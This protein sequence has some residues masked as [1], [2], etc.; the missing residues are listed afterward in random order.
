MS[1][2]TKSENKVRRRAKKRARKAA[3]QAKYDAWKAN[4][5]N[6]KSKRVALRSERSRTARNVKH[7]LGPCGNIGCK[8]CNPIPVNLVTPAFRFMMQ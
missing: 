5:N 8:T 3:N 2:R 7:R 4:G 6:T 1:K